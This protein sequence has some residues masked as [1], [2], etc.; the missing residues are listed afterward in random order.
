MRTA[1]A[2]LHG[3]LATSALAVA[4]GANAPQA[5]TVQAAATPTTTTSD[6][7]ELGA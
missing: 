5:L 7:P 4:L 2:A 6:A 3:Q 1:T